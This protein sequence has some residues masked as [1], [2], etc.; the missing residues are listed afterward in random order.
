MNNPT[1][2][3]R[4]I[5]IYNDQVIH[6][7]IHSKHSISYVECNINLP[8]THIYRLNATWETLNKTCVIVH[9]LTHNLNLY[10]FAEFLEKKINLTMLSLEINLFFTLNFHLI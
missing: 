7:K 2:I 6:L 9:I 5:L 1:Q 3:N 4:R 10:S 8:T